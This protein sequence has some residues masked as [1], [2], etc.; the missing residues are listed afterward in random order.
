[1][2]KRKFLTLDDL[3]NFYSSTSKRNRHFSSKD[4]NSNIVVQTPG[5][6]I[7]EEDNK[8][9]EG[10]LPVRLQ[11]CHTLKNLNKSYIS[12]EVMTNALPSF[13]NRPILG[14]LHTV[15]GQ[16]EFEGHNMHIEDGEVVYD[17]IPVGV[18]PS[19]NDI[20]LEYDEEKGKNYVCVNGYIFEEYTKAAEVLRR[21]EECAVSVELSIRELS[22][23]AKDK[24]LVI[25]DMYFSGV[26]ILGKTDDGDDVLPGMEG[27]NIKLADFQQNN[28]F[29]RID[30]IEQKLDS[31][32]INYNQRKEDST[33]GDENKNFAEDEN[34]ETPVNE[35]E[36]PAT[37][38]EETG[39]TEDVK[40]EESVEDTPEVGVVETK[41]SI[42]YTVKYNGKEF[43]YSTTLNEKLNA[44]YEL[45]N[46]VYAE[47]NDWYT[48]DADDRYVFMFGWFNSYRQRYVEDEKGNIS[49]EGERVEIFRRYLTQ[50]EIDSLEALM[51]ANDYMK[52]KLDEYEADELEKNKI[53][54]LS[55]EDYSSISETPEFKEL[56]ENHSEFSLEDLTSKC[57]ELL[58]NSVKNQN[59]SNY[60]QK[61]TNITVKPIIVTEVTKRGR[62]G[63]AF[64]KND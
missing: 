33:V 36:E 2:G 53:A 38:E 19:D 62:Y 54:V 40:P 42:D 47:D 31:L 29:S 52:K 35:N 49:F 32:L 34:N 26:T 10:L 20:K 5:V 12:D 46:T 37:T 57:D 27:S 6:L 18:I 1:M 9:T 45:V 24:V 25:E 61:T 23:N 58:L 56:V 28:I 43:N 63:G 60:E 39:T 11:A 48:V 4:E 16:V 41:N 51:D 17:E 59:K 21:E 15:D 14:Y 22:Y 7:F 55:S 50:E 44:L 3:Y 13:A 64:K 30:D 8:D